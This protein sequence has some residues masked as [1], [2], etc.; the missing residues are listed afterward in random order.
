M[1]VVFRYAVITAHMPFCLIPEILNP[2]EL[3]FLFGKFLRMIDP[4][5]VEL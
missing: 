2:V 1:E 3:V 5:M 4:D